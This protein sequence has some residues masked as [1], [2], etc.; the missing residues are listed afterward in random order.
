MHHPFAE[1]FFPTVKYEAVANRNSGHYV[2]SC[3]LP[4]E[5]IMCAWVSKPTLRQQQPAAV[6]CLYCDWEVGKRSF[7]TS[8][9][10]IYQGFRLQP[11]DEKYELRG[12]ISPQIGMKIYNIETTT[13]SIHSIATP[14]YLTY[15]S[16]LEM[17]G[18]VTSKVWV[19]NQSIQQ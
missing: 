9:W 14:S 3:I 16:Y 11:R 12:I 13:K 7:L 15:L 2:C 17:Y 18:N 4:N 19:L 6:A 8:I 1:R 5:L 10:S